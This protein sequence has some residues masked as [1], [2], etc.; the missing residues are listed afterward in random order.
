[1]V[2][3]KYELKILIFGQKKINFDIIRGKFIKKMLRFV[4][5][6][7]GDHLPKGFKYVSDTLT[8]K[9]KCNIVTVV[10]AFIFKIF[11]FLLRK[12]YLEI[13]SVKTLISIADFIFIQA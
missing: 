3:G 4:M 12:E 9:L 8:M 6:R 5:R 7:E 1:M 13:S 2:T 11:C 10:Q